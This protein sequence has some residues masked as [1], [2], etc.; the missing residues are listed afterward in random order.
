[1]PMVD[2]K[3]LELGKRTARYRREIP[4][5]LRKTLGKREWKIPLG[6]RLSPAEAATRCEALA[7]EHDALIASLRTGQANTF[8]AA[9][10]IE[11]E[12]RSIISK[13]SDFAAESLA[14]ARDAAVA[15]FMQANPRRAT[16]TGAKLDDYNAQLFTAVRSGGK[17]PD[18]PNL[19]AVYAADVERYGGARRDEKSIKTAVEQWLKW[20][21]DTDFVAPKRQEVE[22]FVAK[23]RKAKLTDSSIARRIGALRGINTRARRIRDLDGRSLA[24]SGLGLKLGSPQAK[25]LPFHS[26][27]I[28]LIN[29]FIRDSAK[30]S[31]ETKRLLRVMKALGLGPAEAAGVKAEDVDL[32]AAI[33]CVFIRENEDRALKTGEAIRA[34]LLPLVGDGLEVFKEAVAAP[35]GKLLFCKGKLDPASISAKLN[36]AI[37]AAGVPKSKRLTAY[38]FR[39]GFQTALEETGLLSDGLVSYAMGHAQTEV[40]DNYRPP[41][42]ALERLRD[43]FV[44]ADKVRGRVNPLNY[45]AEELPAKHR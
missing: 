37:R 8:A 23:A 1:M 3:Y 43:A 41:L 28:G 12:A 39:H 26:W 20:V 18:R 30:S 42:Q 9:A 44:E 36:K 7:R 16:A 15:E 40:K 31:D 2:V 14:Q 35:A 5:D 33:P 22:L 4:A 19:S 29:D 11:R 34:R 21:G 32:S 17:L 24:W 27:H 45:S 38:S 10:A 13:G 25:R 6:A